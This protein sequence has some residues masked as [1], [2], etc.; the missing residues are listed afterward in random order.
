MQK[1]LEADH[2]E[3]DIQILGVNAWDHSSGND[4]ITD[5]RDL[6]WLQDVPEEDVWTSWNPVLR[7]VVIVDAGNVK[8]GVFNLGTYNLLI[9]EN[10]NALRD[11]L[12]AAASPQPEPVPTTSQWGGLVLASLLLLA[13]VVAGRRASPSA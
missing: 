6:P 2:P 1:E 12:I 11:L 4:S 3:L 9:P 5:G 7:D 8:L 13:G 10:Y